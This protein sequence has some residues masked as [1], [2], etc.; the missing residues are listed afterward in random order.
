MT[1][2]FCLS[3][4]VP[5]FNKLFTC[6]KAQILH[7][8]LVKNGLFFNVYQCNLLLQSYIN[9]GSLSIAQN[10]LQFLPH[11]NVVSFNTILSG[12]F[13][14]NLVSQALK[15]FNSSPQKDCHS[16]N[17]AI[18]GCVKNQR[19]DLALAHS[20]RMRRSLVRP[21]EFTYS[22]VLP[23][24]DLG[25]GQQVHAEVVKI[26]SGSDAFLGTN[27]VRM[28]VGNGDIESAGKLFDEMTVRDSVMWNALISCYSKRGMVD[29]SVDLFCRTGREG[30]V[31]DGYTYAIVLNEFVSRSQVFA[32]RQVHSL[33]VRNGLFSDCFITKSLLN[34]Y[35]KCGLISSAFLLFQ[36]MPNKDVVSWTV[37]IS[38]SSQSGHFK[39]ALWL[40]HEMHLT[41]VK[42]NSY[43]FK[44]FG[45]CLR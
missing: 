29:A 1:T 16:W 12:F 15:I 27:L 23:C 37:I 36:E 28:Y 39:E 13:K 34:L 40:F 6:T 26:C 33:I 42:P 5:I 19:L 7:A 45:E 14:S 35:A 9:S 44:W 20:V 38:G 25:F 30:I 43:T 31:A 10:L 3:T 21:D 18:S 2:L 22:I 24:C 4:K 32:A 8:H 17:I 41:Q 11:T